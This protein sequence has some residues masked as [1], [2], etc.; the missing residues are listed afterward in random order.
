MYISVQVGQ[1]EI[2]I[3]ERALT[4]I[5]GI[6]TGLL[7]LGL[8]CQVMQDV[9][10]LSHRIIMVKVASPCV[11]HFLPKPV[12]SHIYVYHSYSVRVYVRL[13]LTLIVTKT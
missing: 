2:A 7:M 11:K 10:A 5:A 6:M 9:K 1:Q 13:H 8:E 12:E 4:A 3:F